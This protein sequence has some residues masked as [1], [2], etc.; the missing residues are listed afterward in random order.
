MAVVVS[1]TNLGLIV[2][3]LGVSDY[4]GWPFWRVKTAWMVKGALP[5]GGFEWVRV[6][7]IHDAR[8]RPIRPGYQD[9]GAERDLKRHAE[10]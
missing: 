10:A 3:V 5:E 2:E 1:G 8:L 6:G 9:V 7:S 4:Y